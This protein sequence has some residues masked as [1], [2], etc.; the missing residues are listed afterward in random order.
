MVLCDDSLKKSKNLY[1]KNTQNMQKVSKLS[2]MMW[3]RESTLRR[4]RDMTI[5]MVISKVF[6]I[7]RNF[8]KNKLFL[9]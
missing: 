6:I 2:P 3:Y 8:F 7:P 4:F 1:L 5:S 9:N